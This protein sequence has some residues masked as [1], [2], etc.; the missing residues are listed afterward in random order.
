M[1]MINEL[2]REYLPIAQ[3]LIDELLTPASE[4]NATCGAPDPTAGCAELAT[5]CMDEKLL[6]ESIRQV[7]VNF[8]RPSPSIHW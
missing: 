7:L 8:V 4:I 5:W 6:Q 2:P 1:Q 3:S